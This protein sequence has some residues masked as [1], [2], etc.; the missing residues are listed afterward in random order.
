MKTNKNKIDA[1]EIR[2]DPVKGEWV[3]IATARGKRPH[4]FSG[5]PATIKQSKSSCPFENPFLEKKPIDVFLKKGGKNEEKDWS[6]V[7][8]PNKFPALSNGGPLKLR[9][10]GP[11]N[12]MRGVGAHELII[13]R[14]HDKF[15]PDLSKD[16]VKDMILAYKKRYIDL[17]KEKIIEYILILHNH[18]RA[19]GS[20][21]R[22][23]HSQIIA[24]PVVPIDVL[25]SINSSKK[26][27]QK[28]KKCVHCEM[29]QYEIKSKKRIICQNKKFVAFIPFASRIAFEIRIFPKEH[30]SSFAQLKEEDI[31]FFGDLLQ[32]SLGKLRSGLNDPAFNFFIHSTPTKGKHEH[33]HWHLSILPKTS[34]W[35]GYEIGSGMEISAVLPEEAARFLKNVKL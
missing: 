33:Y 10:E 20:S 5:E 13:M 19:A 11:Y 6:L 14:D 29:V 24:P 35:A 8:L 7:V 3:I 31:K 30:Q 4:A 16:E 27:F 21:L 12:I 26:Y 23:L 18:G 22:H 34:I 2:Q 1:S 28:H 32:K 15:I 9:K 17:S 25:R